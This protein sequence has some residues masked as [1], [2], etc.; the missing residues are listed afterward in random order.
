[1][2]DD[3]SQGRAAQE[4]Q[5]RRRRSD[6]GVSAAKRLPIP[7]EVQAW[8]DANDMHLRWV[9]DEGNRMHQLTQQDDYDKVEGVEP[10]PVST[11]VDGKP[12]DA[13]LLAKPKQ[14]MR[15]DQDRAERQRKQTEDALFRSAD[16]PDRA[17]AGAN[18]NPATAQRY[19]T[20][21]TKIGRANQVLD[22]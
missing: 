11:G 1:M 15:E 13:H 16:A 14:F 7:P 5:R 22:G 17:A 8:A 12:I 10:V 9:N 20:S 2:A 4:T 18:P 21:D 6:E 19:V 3:R